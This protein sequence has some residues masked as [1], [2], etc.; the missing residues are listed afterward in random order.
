MA[1][2]LAIDGVGDDFSQDVEPAL[3]GRVVLDAGPAADEHLAMGGLGLDHRWGE[4]GIVGGHIAPA[5]QFQPFGFRHALHDGLAIDALRGVARHE[6]MAD[7]VLPRLGQLDACRAA[8]HAE[9]VVWDLHQDAGAVARERV[10][11]RRA[12]MGEVDEDLEAVLDD[13]VAHA[14]LQVGDEAHA[15]GIMLVLGIVE[16]LR[17]RRARRPL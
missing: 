16:S 1:A 15:A 5:K 11:A 9:E 10:G 14:P 12:A 7:G 17:W 8:R 6:H 3:E 4:A 13:L 2:G